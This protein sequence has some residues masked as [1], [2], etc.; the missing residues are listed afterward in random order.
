MS[1]QLQAA[2]AVFLTNPVAFFLL[3]DYPGYA[4]F[5]ACSVVLLAGTFLYMWSERPA[6]SGIGRQ[7]V[8]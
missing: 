6:N 7:P 3:W 2:F 4:G 5:L 1:R 8:S